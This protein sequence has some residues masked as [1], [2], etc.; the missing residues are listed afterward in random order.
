MIDED[1]LK[2]GEGMKISKKK[3]LAFIRYKIATDIKWL[4]AAI[5]KISDSQTPE[6]RL[7]KTTKVHNNVGFGKT[8]SFIVVYAED[9]KRGVKISEGRIEWL[10]KTMQ[11]YSQQILD[12]CNL[13]HL[14][15]LIVDLEKHKWRSEPNT[16]QMRLEI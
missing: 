7:S 5:L 16:I 6:E 2:F 14:D 3:R 15:S 4:N 8:H 11:M 10:K 13:A 9:I 12:K 1:E